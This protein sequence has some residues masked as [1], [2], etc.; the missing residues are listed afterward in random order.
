VHA[1]PNLV[2]SVAHVRSYAATVKRTARDRELAEVGMAI[3]E[4]AHAGDD[5]QLARAESRLAKVGE[6]RAERPTREHR[7]EALLDHVERGELDLPQWPW[8]TLNEMTG[9]IWPGHLTILGGITRHGKSV[10][11]DQVLEHRSAARSG[12]PR[13]RSTRQRCRRSSA[14]CAR[15]RATVTCR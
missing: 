9:G 10:I 15:W 11:L 4:A 14:T 1:L 5:E 8:A 2:P 12:R 6:E 7:F 13:V 3:A